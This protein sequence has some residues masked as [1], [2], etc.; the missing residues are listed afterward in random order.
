MVRWIYKG[1]LKDRIRSDSL[2][3]KLGINNIQ[4]LRYSRLRRFGQAARNDGCINSIIALEVD[5]HGWQGIPRKTWRDTINNDRKYWKLTRV[6]PASR[7]EW[8]KKLRT[9]MGAVRPTLSRTSTL[10][11][12]WWWWWWWWW[13]IGIISIHSIPFHYG[14]PTM[15]HHEFR[16]TRKIFSNMLKL[17]DELC[18][19]V[20]WVK[21][22]WS[23]ILSL[24]NQ[25]PP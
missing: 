10:N 12:W 14:N 7:I 1:R 21:Q 16:I 22:F 19:W 24:I 6:D 9:N 23:D 17:L 2:L 20:I 18:I 3:E 8:R 11:K 4:T 25:K 15:T 5:G 13:W